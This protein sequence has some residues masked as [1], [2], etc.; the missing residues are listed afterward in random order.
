M[1][2]DTRDPTPLLKEIRDDKTATIIIHANAS[3]SHTILLKVGAGP[4]RR[5]RRGASLSLPCPPPPELATAPSLP[6]VSPKRKGQMGL[7]LEKHHLPVQPDSPQPEP[8]LPGSVG[9]QEGATALG[10]QG[11]VPRSIEVF[12][13]V[14]SQGSPT[15]VYSRASALWVLPAQRTGF[16]S[17]A[18]GLPSLILSVPKWGSYPIFPGQAKRLGLRAMNGEEQGWARTCYL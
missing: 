12:P 2:D 17:A 11:S 18:V 1:L 8:S 5:G 14:D 4:G 6:Q 13:G 10:G 16:L 9:S 15:S 7:M 3:M